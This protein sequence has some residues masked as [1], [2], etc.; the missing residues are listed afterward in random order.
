MA[1]RL[2]DFF[3]RRARHYERILSLPFFKA[4]ERD[5]VE[6]ILRMVDARGKT[7]LDMGSGPGKFCRLWGSQDARLVVGIDFSSEMISIARDKC[8]PN[9]LLGDAFNLPFHGGSFDIVSCIGLANYYRDITPLLEEIMRVGEEFIISF[10]GASMLGRVY[11]RISPVEIYLRTR[12]DVEEL[13]S[14]HS[15]DFSVAECASGLT[16]L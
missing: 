10:P 5:E 9:F 11:R 12:G 13:L 15:T 4:L 14:L 7:V 6:G 8:G 2:I 3:D 16:L 1:S